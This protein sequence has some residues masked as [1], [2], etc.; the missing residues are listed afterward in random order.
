MAGTAGEGKMP[1]AGISDQSAAHGAKNGRGRRRGA[2]SFD[3]C[4]QYSVMNG[5]S[6]T[7]DKGVA[8]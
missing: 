4:Y 1:I 8:D 2:Q 6:D 7:T 5:R 3:E